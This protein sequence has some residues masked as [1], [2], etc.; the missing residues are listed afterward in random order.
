MIRLFSHARVLNIYRHSYNFCERNNLIIVT[1]VR[2][3][4]GYLNLLRI[5]QQ[6]FL[7]LPV[8][9]YNWHSLSFIHLL[10][11]WLKELHHFL[12]KLDCHILCGSTTDSASSWNHFQEC[13]VIL[14]S[15]TVISTSLAWLIHWLIIL[16]T[17]TVIT[18]HAC[19]RG[20]VIG[21]VVVVV[22]VAQKSPNLKKKK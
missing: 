14:S 18:L 12:H 21:R 10:E 13:V 7:Q 11:D 5:I 15:I 6:L 3:I 19:A 17:V 4:V 16:S 9:K 2:S 1:W 8:L 22:V 20:K